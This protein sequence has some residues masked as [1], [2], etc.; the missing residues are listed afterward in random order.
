MTT[1]TVTLHNRMGTE[2]PGHSLEELVD[3]MIDALL[4]SI[5][6][7]RERS[8][9]QAVHDARRQ[10]QAGDLDGALASFASADTANAPASEAR[11][12]YGEWLGLARRRFADREG[13]RVQRGHGAGR[14]PGSQ[15]RRLAGGRGGPRHAMAAGA[16]RLA[17]QPAGP[18]APV[19]RCVMVTVNVDIAALKRR[20]PLGDVVEDSGVQLRGRGRVRQGVCPFHEETEGS[21]TVYADSERWFCFGCGEGG[22]VLDFVRRVESLTLPSGHSAAGRQPWARAQGRQPSSRSAAS[23]GRRAAPQG[24]QPADGGRPVLRRAAA[25]RAQGSGVPGLPW[26]RA[27]HRSPPGPRLCPGQ[28][29]AAG[30]GVPG[31]LREASQGLRAVHGAGRR[32]VRRHGRRSRRLRRPRPLAHGPG[33]RPRPDAPVPGV[34]PARSRCWAWGVSAA[35]P[36]GRSS[37]RASSTGSPLPAGTSLPAP[38]WAPRAL[39]GSPTPS[40]GCA[41]V[42]LAFD[43]D[44]AGR[45]ATER[46]QTL[47]G[48]RAAAVVLPP[49]IGDVAELAV[50]PHGRATFMGLLALAALSAR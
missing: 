35:R 41:R 19:R 39:S 27:R 36:C 24:S 47:L 45:E 17:A 2:Q 13:P 16:D 11:W 43:A 21:F 4:G 40:G 44:D 9:A 5:G 28:R 30:P 10:R 49:G 48:R 32:A 22:D 23:G 1:A 25:P 50:L 31:L 37:R 18:P 3:R 6:G 46:L 12:A 15:G 38:P 8:V 14:R 26:R 42:F 29:A 20:H 7:K 34:C 33:D